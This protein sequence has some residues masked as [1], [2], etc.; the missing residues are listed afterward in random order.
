MDLVCL[1]HSDALLLATVNSFLSL[2]NVSSAN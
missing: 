1:D 2:Y